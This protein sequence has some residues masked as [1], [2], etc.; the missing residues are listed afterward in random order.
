MVLFGKTE[1]YW[2]LFDRHVMPATI[3]QHFVNVQHSI[4]H[5]FS[6]LRYWTSKVLLCSVIC[7][8]EC[9]ILRKDDAIAPTKKI[10]T[11]L[12][13]KCL[14]FVDFT[15]I[16][17][18]LPIWRFQVEW[19]LINSLYPFHATGLLLYLLKTRA[20]VFSGGIER[21]QWHEMG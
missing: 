21:N 8:T 4:V 6:T 13:C 16:I 15:K 12:S 1:D 5:L 10:R 11:S 18:L 2:L 19:A 9:Y 7:G 17:T 3:E 20:N 14:W